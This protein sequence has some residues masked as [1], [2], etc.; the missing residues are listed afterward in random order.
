LANAAWIPACAGMTGNYMRE[1]HL[2]HPHAKACCK[3]V[4]IE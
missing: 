2:N 4:C 1:I 3:L